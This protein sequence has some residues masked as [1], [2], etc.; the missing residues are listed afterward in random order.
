MPS[1]LDR[2]PLHLRKYVV[3]QNYDRYTA[4][5]QAAWRFIMRQ[6]KDFLSLHAHPCYVEGLKKTGISVE[7]IPRIEV[8]NDRLEAFGWGAIPVSGFIPPAAFMEF[9]SLGLLPIASD[10]R[11]VDHLAYTPAPDI[12]H[13][14]AGHAPILIQ[15]EFAAYLKKYADVARN[16]ILTREDLNQYAAIRELSDVKENPRSTQNDIR[17]AEEDLAKVN[18]EVKVLSE[19]GW[20]SRMNWWTAE[21]GLIGRLENP[22]IYGAGL[23]SSVGESR[24]CLAAKVQKIPISIDCI[25]IGYD[26]TEPQPQ[27]FVTPDFSAL[28]TVLEDLAERMAFRLG[29][30]LGLDRAIQARTV[31]TVQFETGLQVSGVLE[32]YQ[33]RAPS[34]QATFLRFRG[35]VALSVNG[36][37]LPGHGIDTHAEGFSSP[38]GRPKGLGE[39]LC[40][41]NEHQINKLNLAPGRVTQIQFESGIQLKGEVVHLHRLRDQLVLI[42]FRNVEI[43]QDAEILF[44]P[45]WGV[46]DLAVAEEICSVFGGPADRAKYADTD[47]FVATRVPARVLTPQQNEENAFYQSIRDFRNDLNGQ[48]D[49]AKSVRLHELA[50]QWLKN[51]RGLWLAGLEIIEL[52]DLYDLNLNKREE[53]Q[54]ELQRIGASHPKLGEVIDDGLRLSGVRL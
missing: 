15:P 37:E 10:M 42:R 38:L 49:E 12:V 30:V 6:L 7:S 16:A 32:S 31:N 3:E 19:A 25:Q 34:N 36:Q 26:I 35:P 21:Y 4:E 11:S 20:L 24:H 17:K 45:E 22:R 40:R 13:E 52:S 51:H 50:A 5:D 33:T 14:A 44:R 41:A 27:L 23:L 54:S 28:V 8:M 47:T 53:L 29:G 2:V 46:F 48:K 18:A 43:R 1:A 39:P 9:Q